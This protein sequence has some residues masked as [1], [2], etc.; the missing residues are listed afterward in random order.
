MRAEDQEMVSSLHANIDDLPSG[1]VTDSPFLSAKLLV[2]RTQSASLMIQ[3]DYGLSALNGTLPDL[4]MNRN[5][6]S[7]C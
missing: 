1:T 4:G 2:S 6:R 3:N 5:G 7:F